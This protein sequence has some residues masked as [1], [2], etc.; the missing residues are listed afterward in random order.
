M[1]GF[2]L[3][4]E[5]SG[6]RGPGGAAVDGPGLDG[7][8]HSGQG[9]PS[10]RVAACTRRSVRGGRKT[11]AGLYGWRSD[12]GSHGHQGGARDGVAEVD[13]GAGVEAGGLQAAGQPTPRKQAWSQAIWPAA[14]SRIR[15]GGGDAVRAHFIRAPPPRRATPSGAPPGSG[16]SPPPVPGRSRPAPPVR[17]RHRLRPA[18]PATPADARA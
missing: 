6:A 15:A 5:G 3:S 8:Y 1:A 10:D 17:K 2:D 4:T 18:P 14:S 16:S 11:T 7:R 13:P 9:G 12:G